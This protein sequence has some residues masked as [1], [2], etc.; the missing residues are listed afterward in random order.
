MDLVAMSIGQLPGRPLRGPRD[1]HGPP[2]AARLFQ[3]ESQ[4]P[5]GIGGNQ[6]DLHVRLSTGI[7]SSDKAAG[8]APLRNHS[9]YAV[10]EQGIGGLAEPSPCKK[11][12]PKRDQV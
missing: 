5:A 12:G 9:K 6:D 3:D 11:P 2:V 7:E 1:E 8:D 4:A 10:F